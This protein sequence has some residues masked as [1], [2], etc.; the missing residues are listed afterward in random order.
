MLNNY[1]ILDATAR[2][3][4]KN[5]TD[6]QHKLVN[7]TPLFYYFYFVI[8]VYLIL[9][10]KIFKEILLKYKYIVIIMYFIALAYYYYIEIGDKIGNPFPYIK[11]C[12]IMNVFYNSIS[13][14][15]FYIVA[16]YITTKFRYIFKMF[17]IIGRYS[18]PAY[19]IHVLVINKLTHY[20]P[21]TQY[22][23]SS[24]TYF[25]LTVTISIFICYVLNYL[26]YS[27]YLIGNKSKF[28]MKK[29]INILKKFG[30]LLIN[31]IFPTLKK[32]LKNTLNI[33]RT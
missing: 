28:N 13:I 14:L 31:I 1:G 8:G 16:Y 25:L 33:N 30:I 3:L 2:F 20:I 22:L 26:P 18:F 24:I 19:L 12:T 15:F 32:I 9:N 5:P 6:L 29:L 17:E 21:V 23:S 10:Y 11:S 7:I 27:E 4:F